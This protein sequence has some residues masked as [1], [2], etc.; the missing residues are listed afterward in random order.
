MNWWSHVNW[1]VIALAVS[2]F[3]GAILTLIIVAK[4]LRMI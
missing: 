4:L 1:T 3:V 2:M